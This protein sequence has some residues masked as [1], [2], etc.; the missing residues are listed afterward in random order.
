[1]NGFSI[2]WLERKENRLDNKVYENILSSKTSKVTNSWGLISITVA[3]NHWIEFQENQSIFS[4]YVMLCDVC[5]NCELLV[6]VVVDRCKEDGAQRLDLS[7][8]SISQLPSSMN[9]VTH[10]VEFYLYR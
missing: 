10:L 3:W 4:K 7:N 2:L 9:N 1:M 5:V 8:S 6:V